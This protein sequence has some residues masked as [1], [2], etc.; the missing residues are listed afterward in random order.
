M[1]KPVSVYQT[2]RQQVS[3][4]R[5]ELDRHK[6]A[7]CVSYENRIKA[8]KVKMS[9]IIGESQVEY[10]IL[11]LRE[12]TLNQEEEKKRSQ[13]PDAQKRLE[14]DLQYK[15]KRQIQKRDE[16]SQWGHNNQLVSLRIKVRTMEEVVEQAQRMHKKTMPREDLDSQLAKLRRLRDVTFDDLHAF[17][18]KREQNKWRQWDKSNPNDK[19]SR[20]QVISQ[21]R[22]LVFEH[23]SEPLIKLLQRV[24]PRLVKLERELSWLFEVNERMVHI[25][26]CHFGGEFVRLF[27]FAPNID[28]TDNQTHYVSQSDTV[29][30]GTNRAQP[31]RSFRQKMKPTLG[32]SRMGQTTHADAQLKIESA[33]AHKIS[34]MTGLTHMRSSRLTNVVVKSPLSR[35][36]V[37]LFSRKDDELSEDG[38]PIGTAEPS[39]E[40]VSCESRGSISDKPLEIEEPAKPKRRKPPKI[41]QIVTDILKKKET[42]RRARQKREE[43]EAAKSNWLKLAK[44]SID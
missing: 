41:P 17:V 19:M 44:S 3:E 18:R 5:Q 30:V 24:E 29:S 42:L 43:E 40:T 26:R 37:T 16:L 15:I 33:T 4:V 14:A 12:R 6:N 27:E 22:N 36:Q 10:E 31:A 25:C 9:Q 21:K 34:N 11:H 13:Q 38:Q 1:K 8:N 35:G 23:N 2:L 7:E 39:K 28:F 20:F 32:Q